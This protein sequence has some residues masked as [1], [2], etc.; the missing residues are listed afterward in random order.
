MCRATDLYE[1]ER[2]AGA[3][4]RRV[5]IVDDLHDYVQSLVWLLKFAGCE[6]HTVA[7]GAHVVDEVRTLRPDVVFVDFD[8]GPDPTALEIA[9]QLRAARL[10]SPPLFVVISGW[11]RP[12]QRR[13]AHEAG[14][15]IF[16]IKPVDP[17][18]LISI[19]LQGDRRRSRTAI[20]PNGIERRWRGDVG[21]A[22]R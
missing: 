21:A 9:S 22:A 4:K 6:V 15:D 1:P 11:T 8:L 14:C 20:P 3:Q 17:P 12:A 5:L 2:P 10:P 7:G 16:L 18:Q 13:A 19:A